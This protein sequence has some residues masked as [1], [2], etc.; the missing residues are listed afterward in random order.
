MSLL[1]QFIKEIEDHTGKDFDLNNR[2]CFF[3]LEAKIKG[4]HADKL[5]KLNL[6]E[7]VLKSENHENSLHD[8]SME[9]TRKRYKDC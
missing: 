8:S 6:I 2:R 7:K 9:Y 4:L 1:K 3:Q 5:R